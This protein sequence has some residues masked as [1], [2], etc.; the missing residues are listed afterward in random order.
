MILRHL[1]MPLGHNLPPNGRPLGRRHRRRDFGL[2]LLLRLLLGPA[3]RAPIPVP[4][5]RDHLLHQLISEL[6]VEVLKLIVFGTAVPSVPSGQSGLEL[7]D[8]HLQLGDLLFL[9]VVVMGE[10]L[11]LP[12]QGQFVVLVLA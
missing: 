7:A 1:G 11:E 4:L 5:A 3:C 12:L 6:F 10:G 9:E 2:L 8:D